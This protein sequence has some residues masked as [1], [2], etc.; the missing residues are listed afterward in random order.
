MNSIRFSAV[1]YEHCKGDFVTFR[2]ANR[3]DV[4]DEQYFEWRFLKR[5]NGSKS[6]IV[7]AE[8][9]NGSKIGS[10]SLTPHHYSLDNRN[11]LFG[12]LGD[13]SVSKEWRGKGIARQMLA[14]MKELRE[15]KELEACIVIPNDDAA[16]PL[17]KEG[18]KTVS[19]I[20]RYIRILNPEVSLRKHIAGKPFA[21]ILTALGTLRDLI[22]K[23]TVDGDSSGYR[24]EFS[25]HFVDSFNNLW[26][27]MDR[28]GIIVGRRDRE[29]LTWR[30]QHHPID[31]FRIFTIS[32]K[33]ELLG[34]I[35]SQIEGE[36]CQ[37]F[38]I[39]SKGKDSFCKMLN[40]FVTYISSNK[41]LISVS[42]RLSDQAARGLPLKRSLFLKRP[43]YLRFMIYSTSQPS[44]FTSE[45][46]RWY[47]TLGDKDV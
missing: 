41:T 34:Y 24:Y 29:Y 33:N 46:A 44:R 3:E 11:V 16:K 47:L 19:T 7:W 32:G 13:I 23:K 6:L 18:W 43:D 36:R 37:I 1:P 12:I 31:K 28:M 9:A 45:E 42:L 40:S 35:V 27:G 30:Y 38:D 22:T 8:D 20:E 15:F 21:A 5:P 4:R 25:D 2:N 14:Y 26:D 17:E 10:I 39:V